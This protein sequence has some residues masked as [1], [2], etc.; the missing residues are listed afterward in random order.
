MLR[1]YNQKLMLTQSGVAGLCGLK[2]REDYIRTVLKIL[3]GNAR[4]ADAIR[5][6]IKMCFGLENAEK[7]LQSQ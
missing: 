4:D 5:K 3:K 6:A 2:S 1:V 7:P